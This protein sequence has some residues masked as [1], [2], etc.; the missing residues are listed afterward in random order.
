V[1]ANAF[2]LNETCW[3]HRNENN[4]PKRKPKRKALGHSKGDY[5]RRHKRTGRRPRG[6]STTSRDNE[7]EL[8][9]EEPNEEDMDDDHE[10]F[11]EKYK[12]IR[13]GRMER[14][15]SLNE[16]ERKRKGGTNAN[17]RTKEYKIEGRDHVTEIW[18]D[19]QINLRDSR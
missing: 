4:K 17:W 1:L 5:R 11:T 7:N 12:Q 6:S 3:G 16:S 8:V 14:W 19:T 13:D 10:A 2:G 18:R 15:N 9:D